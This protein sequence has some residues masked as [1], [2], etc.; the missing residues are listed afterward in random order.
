MQEKEHSLEEIKI[1][2]KQLFD[3]F[4]NENINKLIED[5]IENLNIIKDLRMGEENS[6]S[7]KCDI[8]KNLNENDKLN[9]V[10]GKAGIYIIIN[11]ENE[12][13]FYNTKIFEDVFKKDISKKDIEDRYDQLKK[14]NDKKARI[15]YIGKA[16]NLKSRIKQ[17]L[18]PKANHSGGRT[19]WKIERVNKLGIIWITLQEINDCFENNF[20][21]NYPEVLET[22]LLQN[23]RNNNNPKNTKKY[24]DSILPLANNKGK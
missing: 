15:I 12:L 3:C 23:Y 2:L 13:K 22:T 20:K 8:E 19:I 10:K 21:Y 9:E 24:E 6:N 1:E 7:I 4:N 17:Y 14:C 11:F 5:K 18:V 16:Q